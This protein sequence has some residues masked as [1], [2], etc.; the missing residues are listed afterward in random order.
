MGIFENESDFNKYKF[1]YAVSEY[2]SFSK[3]AEYLHI[4]QPAISHAVKE[5]ESQLNTKLFI[6][7]KKN[8]V[9]TEDGEKLVHYVKKAF[10]NITMGEN[11]IKEKEKSLTGIIRIGI[12]S[13]ISLFMLPKMIREFN[14]LYPEAK[15]YIYSTSNVEMLEKLR[16]R[17]LDFVVLQ[18]PIFVNDNTFTEE[19]LCEMETCFFGDKDH[20]ELFMKNN[21]S[22]KDLSIIL[23]SRGFPDIN[24]LEQT[25]KNHNLIL[26]SSITSYATDLT[27][28]LAKEGLGIGWGIKKCVEQDI[29]DGSLFEIPVGFENFKTKFSIAYDSE[30][31]SN[32][33]MEFIKYFKEEINKYI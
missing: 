33:A 20:Y 12:Y 19:I 29:I 7:D 6:R 3:A 4:S 23:P 31:I 24:R 21:N 30:F 8:V 26:K 28:R 1:F 25:F 10:D 2:K 9:L 17:E 32:T 18:Y 16:N 11:I 14:V 27:R 15:F 13:H 5:L 22:L